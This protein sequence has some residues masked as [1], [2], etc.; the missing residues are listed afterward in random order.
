M[1]DL[2]P[3]FTVNFNDPARKNHMMQSIH[4]RQTIDGLPFQIEGEVLLYGKS[5]GNRSRNGPLAK[6]FED[7]AVWRTFDELHLLHAA[8]WPDVQGR[9]IATIRLKYKDGTKAE[10]PIQYGVHVRD[11]ARLP[12]EEKEAVTDPNTKIA[13]RCQGPVKLNATGRVF[14][15]RL[16]NPHPEKIVGTLEIVSAETEASYSILAATVAKSDPTR[17]VDPPAPSGEPERNYD[18]CLTVRVLNATTG[19]PIAG[20]LVDPGMDVDSA[21]V[22]GQPMLTD[23]KGEAKVRYPVGHTSYVSVSVSG[24]GKSTRARR[25]FHQDNPGASEHVDIELNES[26]T[27]HGVVKDPSGAPAPNVQ[28]SIFP[29]FSSE[30]R[31]KSDAQ[32]KYTLAWDPENFGPGR[33]DRKFAVVAQDLARNL[34]GVEEVEP[35]SKSV[36]VSLEPA[37]TVSG[38]VEDE[39][40]RP[41]AGASVAIIMMVGQMGAPINHENGLSDERGHYEVKSLPAGGNYSAWITAKGYGTAQPE[42]SK[43]ADKAGRLELPASVLRLANQR[44]AGVVQDANQAPL[45]GVHVFTYGDGQA[46]ESVQTDAQGRFQLKVCEGVIHLSASGQSGHAQAKVE[47]GDTNVVLTLQSFDR[48]GRSAMPARTALIGRPLPDLASVNLRK[49]AVK[50]EQPL[51]LCLFDCEQRPSRRYVKLLGEQFAALQQKG[52]SVA[53]VQATVATPEAFK[54]WQEGA[55]LPFPVGRVA[56]KAEPTRWAT[57]IETLPWLVLTDAKG[58]VLAEGFALE[59]LD[60]KLKS[61]GK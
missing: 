36:D 33:P 45:K 28:L 40:G 15:S 31:V 3:G 39:Q 38:S 50:A 53:A 27:I 57:Q 7:I 43:R 6:S 9:T 54:S 19:Q 58:K 20:A 11:W 30:S 59:D 55:P 10:L 17:A 61:V 32:G 25:H 13:L 46:N 60:A 42:M 52:I 56:E 49:E 14:K 26:P 22:V 2:T 18:G 37:L 23:E 35:G 51:L 1:L 5:E 24:E 29:D 12:A 4:G 44:V 41:I 48:M 16:V 47:S 21:G 34:A 8:H